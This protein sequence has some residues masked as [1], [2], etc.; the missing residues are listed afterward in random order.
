[1]SI[2]AAAQFGRE[3]FNVAALYA[4]RGAER[5]EAFQMQINRP[6]ANYAT[7]R[8]S[9][10]RFL[11]PTQQWSKN[12]NRRAH[13]SNNVVRRNRIDLFRSDTHGAA[14]AFHLCAE[15]HQDLQHVMRVAQVRHAMNEASVAREQCR[16]QDRQRR[17]F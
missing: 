15:V 16:S 13:F 7:T 6:V 14:G 17:I 2:F 9:D 11:A 12:T 5:F 1:M 4:H 10:G 3:N 8:Q